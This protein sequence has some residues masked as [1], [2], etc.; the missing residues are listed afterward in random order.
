M[1]EAGKHPSI[2]RVA[3]L[4]RLIVLANTLVAQDRLWTPTRP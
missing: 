1:R 3:I 2:I 4:R